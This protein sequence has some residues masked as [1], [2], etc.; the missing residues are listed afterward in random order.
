MLLYEMCGFDVF[1]LSDIFPIE[2]VRVI[3]NSYRI[4]IFN[5]PCTNNT[6]EVNYNKT[7][8]LKTFSFY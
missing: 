1:V 2:R 4:H 5:L 7:I 3:L 8:S 6:L